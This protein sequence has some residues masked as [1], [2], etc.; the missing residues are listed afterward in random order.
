MFSTQPDMKSCVKSWGNQINQSKRTQFTFLSNL[1]LHFT[2]IFSGFNLALPGVTTLPNGKDPL[3]FGWSSWHWEDHLDE[4][5]NK[6]ELRLVMP[7]TV[8]WSAEDRSSG[9]TPSCGMLAGGFPRFLWSL[10]KPWTKA[11]PEMMNIYQQVMICGRHLWLGC[12]CTEDTLQWRHQDCLPNI[13]KL[14]MP[15]SSE[16]RCF[17]G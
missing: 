17:F 12:T 9:K 11:E 1:K 7:P 13:S 16:Q 2:L 4:L 10:G 14:W 6:G 5:G 15:V 3:R 8:S